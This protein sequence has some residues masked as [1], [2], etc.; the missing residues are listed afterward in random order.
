M[1]NSRRSF[2][3][4]LPMPSLQLPQISL[5]H[6]LMFVVGLL[7]VTYVAL[8]AFTMS[9]AV[10]HTEYAQQARDAEAQVGTLETQYFD[11]LAKVDDTNPAQLG[12]VK[13][14]ARQFAQIPAAPAVATALAL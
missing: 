7:A 11:A 5:A 12:Y 3:V 13:P 2:A 9:Y 8:M 14:E 4:A 10:V 6:G 1:R